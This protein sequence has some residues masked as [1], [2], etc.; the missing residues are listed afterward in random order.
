[1]KRK[2]AVGVLL[3]AICAGWPVRAEDAAPADRAVKLIAYYFHGTFRCATCMKLE[4]YTKEAI[5]ESF[6]DELKNGRIAWS[7][8]NTDEGDNGHF[9]KDFKL[10]TKSVVLVAMQGDKQLRW[11]NLDKIW[12]LVSTKDDFKKYIRKEVSQFRKKD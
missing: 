3:L 1:M 11:K 10:E 7:A 8:V 5:E 9:V 4:S 12:D 6:K 2:T